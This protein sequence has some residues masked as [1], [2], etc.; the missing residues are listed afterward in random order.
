MARLEPAGFI[1]GLWSVISPKQVAVHVRMETL[2]NGQVQITPCFT[3]DGQEVPHQLINPD[4]TQDVLGY[5][6]V[7][8]AS[9]QKVHKQTQ[10]KP[11]RLAKK[12]AAEFLTQLGK[13]GVAI[14]SKD[15]KAEPRIATVKP[16]VSLEL[17]TD[18]TLAVQSE[19]S[20]A[21][22]VVL[23][24]PRSL[25][26]L[27]ED[28][29]W[30]AVGDD[31]LRVET[32]GSLL[33]NILV[34]DGGNGTLSGDDVPRFL[35]LLQDESKHVGAVEKNLPLQSLSVASKALKNQVKVGGD[36]ESISVTPSL[37]YPGKQ[38]RQY[39][40]TIA[41]MRP[42][43]KDGGFRR[44][45]DG[46]LEVTPD[47]IDGFEKARAEL[48]EK[49]GPLDN[50]RG[51]DIPEALSTLVGATKHDGTWSNPWAVYFSEAVKNA[52][53]VIDSAAKVAFSLNIVD[54]D[55]QS[56]LTLDPIYNHER[57][58]LSHSEVENAAQ[59][60]DD[61]VRRRDAWIK[62]DRDKYKKIEAG[63]QLLNLQRGS[64]G[65]TFPASQRE[66]VIDLFSV[67][68]SIEHSAAYADFL[69]KLANF[70][71]IEDV[72]LPRNLRPE[73][74]FR[75]YQK[76]GFNWLAFLHRFGLNG[77]LADD[78]GLGKTLQ[79][80][81]MIQRAREI[82]KSKLPSLIICPTSVVNNWKS[83]VAKF[84]GDCHVIV[85]TGT[86][87]NREKKLRHLRELMSFSDYGLAS[88]LLITSYD[89][90][91]LD[92]E[93]LNRIPWLYV[94]VDEGHNIKNPDTQ[95]TRAIKTIN[96]RH[97]LALTGTPIQNNLEELWSLFD[98][99]MPGFLGTRTEFRDQYGKNGRIN[100]DA[101]R[102]G[103]T[104]LKERVHPFVMR[105]LKETVAKDLP[106]KIV[107]DRKVELTPKQADLYKQICNSAE[108]QQILEEV[109]QKGAARA[110][111]AILAALGKLRAI[112]NH[113]T[114][115]Q[116]PR[117]IR[118]KYE[119]SGKL[120]FLKEL[121]DEVIEGEHR[122]LLFSQSTQMLDII[123]EWFQQWEITTV[124]LDGQ[125]P[126]DKRT[127]LVDHFNGNPSI[128][129]FL[130]STKAGGTGLNLTGA[131]TVIFYDHDWNPANDRQA[132]DRAYRIG[133]TKPVTVYRL[134]SKGTIE[135]KILER[136]ILKQ[137]IA[138][139]II[140]ADIEGF[141]DL[142]KEELL[143]LFTL[144][145]ETD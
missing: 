39:E 145:E 29:G 107:I 33:D 133:Q 138:D 25:D 13:S 17:R 92:H 130:I 101:V 59:N 1:A 9:C 87:N 141:K 12:K 137:G 77:I 116:D 64:N 124:R 60:G 8:D 100:W 65:F 136:Q 50:I 20:T 139:E 22:G 58:Q 21:D 76:H 103:K 118:P 55:V 111:I 142:T 71:K 84:F 36:A 63:V 53:R 34:K 82:T 47:A 68:G 27:I 26:Q 74:E 132:Q 31:F 129:C 114:L 143:A 28:D 104:P 98:Y 121:M 105:R 110:Q 127:A 99:A 10:G 128:H 24:K 122:A 30:Y 89:I 15:G 79:T 61:W 4:K 95:R 6:V 113:P 126:A 70:E 72:P 112:C 144:D 102:R 78:M 120:A 66:Q 7:L 23:E 83:E 32:S 109:A 46:W 106:P 35:K 97:K 41:D 86:G 75:P 38:G 48:V 52:H 73:I 93:E 91:R 43:A 119:D 81:A 123:E 96:G 56:L 88:P 57:F 19:L 5:S 2:P 117:P 49:V 54:S 94:V 134:I 80:L 3:I 85:Y 18:D 45:P 14:R 140:G 62:V 44:V 16:D 42:F 11:T 51:T 90:A 40:N 69:L 131:D 125:T 37:V 67:L 135:E 115:A 108:K